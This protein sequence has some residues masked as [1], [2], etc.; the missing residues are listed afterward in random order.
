[1]TEAPH[2]HWMVRARIAH[3]RLNDNDDNDD[4]DN[5]TGITGDEARLGESPT[6]QEPAEDGRTD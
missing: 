2:P 6:E 4:Q 3:E 1:M 5:D